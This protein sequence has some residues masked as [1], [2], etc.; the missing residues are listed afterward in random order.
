MQK[1]IIL[2]GVGGQGIVTISVVI[3]N[4][5]IKQGLDFRQAEIHGMSQRGGAVESHVRISDKEIYADLIAKGTAD[6][7]I[8]VEPMEALRAVDYLS[9]EGVL[10][11]NTKC[12]KNIA[13]YP[14]E[15]KIM[16]MLGALKVKVFT[17]DAKTAAEDTGSQRAQ[18]I[19]MAGAA[20][21]YIGLDENLMKQSI[22]ELFSSKGQK[23]VDI[24]LKALEAG[25]N[26]LEIL[27]KV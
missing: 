17:I 11:T 1:N 16:Q 7:I 21:K 15:Q 5:A 9:P 19:V 12:V 6:L 18:N 26:R 3:V 20:G 2:A 27:E 4:T 14:E 8:A 10:I 25:K 24:N 23:I 22:K 13:G